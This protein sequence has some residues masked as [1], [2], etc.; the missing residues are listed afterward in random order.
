MA[1]YSFSAPFW[2]LPTMFLSGAAAA[3]S[4]ALINATGNLG[5]FV[6]PYAIGL[7]S[8]LTGTYSAGVFY[9]VGLG[10]LGGLLVLS[11]RAS[12]PAE[13]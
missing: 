7:L 6:G 12:R 3:A 9:L 2:A 13:K 8:D 5:G 4:I 10:L 1:L 11:L